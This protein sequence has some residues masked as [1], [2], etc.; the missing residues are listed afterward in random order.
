MLSLREKSN[1]KVAITV[2]SEDLFKWLEV[3][4]GDIMLSCQWDSQEVN[5]HTSITSAAI[6]WNLMIL[7]KFETIR[8]L[9][10]NGEIV[11]PNV[12]GLACTASSDI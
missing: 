1:D 8:A 7:L 9:N 10:K 12:L 3:L 2:P 6:L 11:I 5:N 4:N